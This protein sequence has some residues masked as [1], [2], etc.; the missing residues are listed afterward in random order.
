[1]VRRVVDVHPQ[2][3]AEG[4]EARIWYRARSQIVEE[5]FRVALRRAI[6]E[7]RK[8]PERWPP[9]ADGL[10]GCRVA[11]FPYRLINWTDGADSL[12]LAIAHARRR[13]GYWKGRLDDQE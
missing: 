12:V 2:A 6:E 5:R 9:D 13:P 11:G 3:I 1:M 4:R 10:R 8:A 7:I